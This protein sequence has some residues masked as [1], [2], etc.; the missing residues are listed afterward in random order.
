MN[1]KKNAAHKCKETTDEYKF[2][3]QYYVPPPVLSIH[4]K[5]G[6][7]LGVIN[8]YRQNQSKRNLH[9]VFSTSKDVILMR[10]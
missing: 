4:G 2:G 7:K 9:K 5:T 8:L 10:H 3:S 1:C 6:I